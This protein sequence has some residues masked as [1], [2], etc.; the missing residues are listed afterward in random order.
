MQK[1]RIGLL[2]KGKQ[3]LGNGRGSWFKFQISSLLI[4]KFQ[5]SRLLGRARSIGRWFDS[6][7]LFSLELLSW[8]DDEFL[9]GDTGEIW[10][11]RLQSKF[12]VLSTCGVKWREKYRPQKYVSPSKIPTQPRRTEYWIAII[13]GIRASENI[14]HNRKQDFQSINSFLAVLTSPKY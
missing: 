10:L 4:A 7:V 11:W 6:W 2:H 5:I 12:A 14:L 1:W 3:F 9:G 13:R 8:V